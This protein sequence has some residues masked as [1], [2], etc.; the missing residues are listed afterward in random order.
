MEAQEAAPSTASLP[1][2]RYA[3]AVFG[4]VHGEVTESARAYRYSQI[5]KSSYYICK[6]GGTENMLIL[7][8]N[9]TLL[10]PPSV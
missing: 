2:L 6:L 10:S 1:H 8:G 5:E 9:V 3:G 7:A 4:R